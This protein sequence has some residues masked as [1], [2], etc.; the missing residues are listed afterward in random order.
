MIVTP[1]VEAYLQGLQPKADPI[2]AEMERRAEERDFPIIGP[3]VGGLLSMLARTSGARRVL[4]LGSGFG[5]SAL[6]FAR[7][8]P[9]DGQVQLTDFSQAAL[10][11]AKAFLE[12]AGMAH[13]A[14]FHTGDGLS[15]A[16]GLEG[17]FDIIFNDIDK[18]HYPEVVA[19]AV[20]LL[21]PG[22]MLITDNALWYGKPADPQVSDE[23][24][25]GVRKYNRLVFENPGLQTV[26]L[27]LRDGVAISLKRDPAS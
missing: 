13:K 19:P 16:S 1:Q 7:A 14:R 26:I 15:T 8:L 23:A 25:E 18:E 24:T 9:P 10:D 11:E 6:W 4:E 22:G 3:Q 21:R 17:P 20:A 12:R 27:P 2:L 5:Y